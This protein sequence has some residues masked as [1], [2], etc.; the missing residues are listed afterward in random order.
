MTETVSYTQKKTE[1]KNSVFFYLP[2]FSI[3][4]GYLKQERGD[5]L[6]AGIDEAG[7]GA[8]AGPLAVA[9]TIYSCK[10][11]FNPGENLNCI[12][13][14]KKLTPAKRTKAASFIKSTAL[15]SDTVFIDNCKI[16][17]YNINQATRTAIV[18]LVEGSRVR[19]DL[20]LV[21]GGFKFDLPIPY[22]AIKG[23]DSISVSIASASII[24]KVE[25]D[26]YMKQC[27]GQYPEYGFGQHMGYG[28]RRH[29]EAIMKN[30]PS[31]IHRRSYEPLRSMMENSTN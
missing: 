13:D 31:P 3:E 1:K 4:K 28:T 12:N 25:R 14:S 29:I 26:E 19:P 11:I 18:E 30:G 2:D 7:R 22:F 10:Y 20:L 21:D 15:Y 17:Q 5:M 27:C 24:A 6:I 9:I 8:L 16:D 23:G